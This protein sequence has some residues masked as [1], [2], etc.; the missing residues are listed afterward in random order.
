MKKRG[1]FDYLHT[2]HDDEVTH[3]SHT[4]K[5]VVFWLILLFFLLYLK[6]KPYTSN[7]EIIKG[8]TEYLFYLYHFIINQ[9][10]GIVHEGGHGIC[11]L[12]PCP[13]FIIVVNGTLF[14]WLFPLG[15]AYY[16]KKHQQ[17]VGYFLGIFILGISLDYTAWYMSTAQES[18]IV[19]ASKSFLDVDGIHDFHYL[20]LL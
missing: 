19:P 3:T 15:V 14:Q 5:Q 16:Y 2:T 20:G 4:T 12:F 10:I 11:Y 6:Y 1:K 17:M 13:R 18:A 7:Q 8:T 9:T